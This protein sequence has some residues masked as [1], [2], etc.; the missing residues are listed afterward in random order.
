MALRGTLKDFG[1]AEI[2]QLIGQQAKTGVLH[3]ESKAKDE[4]VQV[5]FYQ[6]NVVRAEEVGRTKRDFL[7][8]MLVKAGLVSQ[9]QLDEA[10]GEQK[11]TLKRLGDILIEAGAISRD[12]LKEMAQLQASETLFRLFRWKSG[13]YRFEQV[14]VK[15][16]RD[17]FVPIRSE[18]VL[19]EGFRLVD[20]WPI[21]RRKI[22]SSRMTFELLQPLPRSRSQEVDLDSALDRA[23]DGVAQAEPERV[24]LAPA[25]ERVLKLVAPGRTA[26]RLVEL[27]RLGEFETHKALAN[28]VSGGYLSAIAPSPEDEE[29]ERGGAGGF[30]DQVVTVATRLVFTV[31]LA[32]LVAALVHVGRSQGGAGVGTSVEALVLD[33]AAER[34]IADGQLARIGFALEVHRLETGRHPEALVELVERGLL[35]EDDL[36]YPWSEPYFYR[37]LGDRSGYVLLPPLR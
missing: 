31:A 34:A 10:L 1:I 27:S 7:G 9:A 36:R 18:A 29:A 24:R 33:S 23:F 8:S 37:R 5:S 25:D 14:E 2:L 19:M 11:R 28:L 3:L 4:E 22:P 26:R 21:V 32:V 35:R 6:G 13:T 20:E 30:V 15:W 16:D 12:R 17:W